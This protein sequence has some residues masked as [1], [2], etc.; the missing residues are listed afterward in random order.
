MF[1]F[2]TAYRDKQDTLQ[3]INDNAPYGVNDNMYGVGNLWGKQFDFWT[4]LRQGTANEVVQT[5]TAMFNAQ[6]QQEAMSTK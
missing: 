4:A 2:P 3:M 5:Y 6:V 1:K